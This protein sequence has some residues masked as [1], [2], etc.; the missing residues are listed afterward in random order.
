MVSINCLVLPIMGLQAGWATSLWTNIVVGY[1]TYYTA[2]LI[3]THLGRGANIKSCI[4]NHFGQDYRYMRA[5]SLIIWL[6]I[7]PF[8][9]T[10][11]RIICE[12]IEGLIGLRNEWVGIVFA[13]LLAAFLVAVRV[14]H[15]VEETMALG[16]VSIV[17]I[18]AFMSWALASAPAGPKTVP[19]N[20][21]PFALAATLVGAY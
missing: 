4:L 11:F 13:C 12:Q 15:I 18:L 1:L 21:P 5:Y 19:A 2:K 16:V 8:L 14:Y 20:G 3:V 6:S 17:L 7:I 10:Q 9:L